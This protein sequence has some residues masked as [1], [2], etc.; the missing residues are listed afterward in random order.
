MTIDGIFKRLVK[1]N[2]MERYDSDRITLAAGYSKKAEDQA[3]GLLPYRRNDQ[4][5]NQMD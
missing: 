2:N 5:Y 3:N 1:V 4:R